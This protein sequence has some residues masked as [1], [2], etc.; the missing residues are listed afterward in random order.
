MFRGLQ[1]DF[2]EIEYT[3]GMPPVMSDSEYDD[4]DDDDLVVAKHKIDDVPSEYNWMFAS[5]SNQAHIQTPHLPTQS[6][7]NMSSNTDLP[8]ATLNE[9]KLILA[10]KPAENTIGEAIKSTHATKPPGDIGVDLLVRETVIIPPGSV[11]KID[12]GVVAEA[13]MEVPVIVCGRREIHKSPVSY[14]LVP[15]SSI[16]KT[17][18]LMANSIGVIDAGYRGILL[19]MVRN[20]GTVDYVVEAGTR[21]FQIVPIS[22]GKGFDEVRI[23]ESVSETV[24]GAGGFGSTGV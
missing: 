5:N 17:P 16:S 20:L 1:S 6:H 22:N 4:N 13:F 10:L 11:G 15:R 23:V 14:F 18:L 24:R 2:G 3:P 9:Y 19:A 7:I 8:I 12:L 21:L